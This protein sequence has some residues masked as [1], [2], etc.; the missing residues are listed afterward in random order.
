MKYAKASAV[1]AL[2]LALFFL[3]QLAAELSFTLAPV[4]SGTDRPEMGLKSLALASRLQTD[5][6]F[7]WLEAG[8]EKAD[9]D[10]TVRASMALLRRS[11]A[12]NPLDYQARYYLAKSY[13]RFSAVGNDYFERGV[14]E[15]RRAAAIRGGNRHIAVDCAKVFFSLWP[16]LEPEDQAF[17]ESLLAGVMPV[18]SWGEFAPLV[19]SWALYVQDV[20]V[21]MG[22]L[23]LKPEFFGPAAEQLAASGLP[24]AKRWE[25]LAL[26]E[27]NTLDTM[28]RR[29]NV[30]SLQGGASLEQSLSL[31][32]QARAIKGYNRLHPGASFNRDKFLKLQRTLLIDVIGAMVG[33]ARNDAKQA[34]QLRE[35]V[36]YYI[37]GHPGLNDLDLLQKLLQ[38]RNYFKENDFPS[39]R[40]K[41]L[42]ASRKGDHGG[43]I[44]EIE[45]VRAGISFVKR[46]QV[47]EYTD[48]LL[49]LT[50]SYYR[51]KLMTAAEAVALDLYRNQ[52]DNPDVLWR[53]LRVQNVLGA[54]GALDPELE[55]RLAKIRDSRF[56]AVS[57][58]NI[59]DYAYLFNQPEIEVTLD[60]ALRAKIGPGQLVQVF[61]NEKIAAESYGR[62]LPEKFVIGPPL[63]AI[64]SKAAVRVAAR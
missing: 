49:L 34:A 62:D 37:A 54:E 35:Y 4:P 20:P 48:I 3:S 28:E 55:A 61:V 22:F 43:V 46:E 16:L 57:R 53:V 25:M 32:N 12:R 9:S 50:D 14:L 47:T 27:A 63:V 44:A 17:T 38:E 26:H 18:L 39:L 58:L 1:A 5:T 51:S 6:A 40:L 24:L 36:E 64:E 13:L 31:L 15:L 21:L 42:I 10:G 33:P 7:A 19:E 29:Y 2:L 23:R 60:P 45:A 59:P 56:L 11:I 8:S 52:P 30:L 41:T